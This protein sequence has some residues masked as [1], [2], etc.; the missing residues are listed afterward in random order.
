MAPPVIRHECLDGLS[1]LK[2]DPTSPL[3]LRLAV[4][5]LARYFKKEMRS[6]WLQ[7]DATEMQSSLGYVPYEAHLFHEIA[8]ECIVEDEPLPQ[9]VFGACYFRWREWTDSEPSW[10]LDWI[11]IHPYFRRC[12]HLQQAWPAFQKRYRTAFNVAPPLSIAMEAFV[13]AGTQACQ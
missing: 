11:W 2:I 9:R 5:T 12:G 7:F 3:V 4:E 10:S 8:R 6:D 13:K 1:P